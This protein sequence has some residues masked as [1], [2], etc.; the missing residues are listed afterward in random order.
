MG[1]ITE[2]RRKRRARRCRYCG[3]LFKPLPACP[4]R[5]CSRQCYY[6]GQMKGRKLRVSTRRKISRARQGTHLPPGVGFQ[7]GNIPWNKGLKGFG[8]AEKNSKWRGGSGKWWAAYYTKKAGA[9]CEVPGCGWYRT[10]EAHHLNGN[11]HDWAEHNVLI[12]CPNHHSLTPNHTHQRGSKRI[13]Y[14][15]W[16]L[17]RMKLLTYLEGLH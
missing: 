3:K 5:F 1:T 4:G 2:T 11:E 8:A 13:E 16:M 14:E 17:D 10:L 15:D 12:L 6:E 9:R 7:K